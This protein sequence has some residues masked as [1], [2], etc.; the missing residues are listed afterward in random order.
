MTHKT[1]IEGVDK[2]LKDIMS[3]TELFGSKVIVLGGDFR[4]VLPVVTKGSKAD[5]IQASIV[6]SYIRPQFTQ[7]M[8][9]ISDPDFTVICYA[10]VMELNLTLI[11]RTSEFHDLYFYHTRLKKNLAILTTRNDF[12]D[13][14]NEILTERF[15]GNAYQYISRD[16]ALEI[17]EQ[18]MFEDFFNSLTP[19][20]FPPYKLTLKPNSPIILLRNIDPPG[21]LC[22]GTR[23]ICKSLKPNIIHAII[24]TG[25]H[26]GKEVFLHRISLFELRM[27][28]IALFLLSVISSLLDYALQ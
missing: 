3:S 22:N 27:T 15:P 2:M 18:T 21:G 6:N 17:S 28:L 25:E 1:A 7:N 9:A 16:K 23:L 5:F 24:S 20:G 12:I 19:T 8:R 26:I 13:E 14:L 11:R 4:Q 10:L